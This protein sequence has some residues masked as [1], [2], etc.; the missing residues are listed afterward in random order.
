MA[1]S[2]NESLRD[3]VIAHD[4][5]LRRVVA[6]S[7][8]TFAERQTILERAII[9]ALVE[10]DPL[11]VTGQKR[12]EARLKKF[13]DFVVL[14]TREAY[15]EHNTTLRNE[16]RSLSRAESEIIVG[17]IEELGERIE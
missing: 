9:R 7:Q 3:D 11:G 8:K 14:A 2:A 17:M 13:Q 5:R 4:V 16:L 6:S 12:Q 1:E 15:G 10:I